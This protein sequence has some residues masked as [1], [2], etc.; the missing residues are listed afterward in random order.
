MQRS[1]FT[2]VEV[3]IATMIGGFV[4]AAVGT[5]S[6]NTVLST[7]HVQ[8]RTS[9]MWRWQRL[10]SQ[11]R[12]DMATRID[13]MSPEQSTL[14]LS[15]D[16]DAL[17]ELICLAPSTSTASIMP[18]LVPTRITYS[19]ISD[20]EKSEGKLLTRK[21]SDLTLDEE[22]VHSR[23][24]AMALRGIQLEFWENKQWEKTLKDEKD[25]ALPRAIRLKFNWNDEDR[26]IQTV[27][28]QTTRLG[29]SDAV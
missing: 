6:V 28:L 9:S 10:E 24:V 12:H 19:V 7:K 17:F 13:W 4:L 11:L 26:E 18:Q 27:T 15:P 20:P 22:V 25:K 14:Q 29:K 21:S 3:L 8:Q 5:I 23:I 1:G 16:K 2:L